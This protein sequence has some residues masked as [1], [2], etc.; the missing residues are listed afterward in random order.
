MR[1]IP[2]YTLWVHLFDICFNTQLVLS[3]IIILPN[4]IVLFWIRIPQ[5]PSFIFLFGYIRIFR[6]LVFAPSSKDYYSADA[7]PGIVDA[8]F[9]ID[10][11][12]DQ[13]TRWKIVSEQ[14]AMTAFIIQSASSTLVDV[15]QF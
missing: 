13:V 8:M 10:E 7:F 2:P 1:F 14:M 5:T 15:L 11:D 6:H 4:V 12:P 9:N 3:I